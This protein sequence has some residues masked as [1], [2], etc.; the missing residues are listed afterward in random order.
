MSDNDKTF[1]EAF[2]DLLGKYVAGGVG[3]GHVLYQGASFDERAMHFRM[4]SARDGVE[5]DV[6]VPW[7]NRWFDEVE[8]RPGG[9]PRDAPAA[10]QALYVAALERRAAKAD[11]LLAVAREV[12]ASQSYRAT[13]L[14]MHPSHDVIGS[15]AAQERDDANRLA[16]MIEGQ[17]DYEADS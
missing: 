1:G 14:G 8:S 11:R 5:R 12:A 6:T 4:V 2:R 10:G 3:A 7:T 15:L 17:E 9:L 16:T 13:L